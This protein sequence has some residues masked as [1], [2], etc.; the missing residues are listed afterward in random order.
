MDIGEF[1]KGLRHARQERNLYLVCRFVMVLQQR[2]ISAS[3]STVERRALNK[4]LERVRAGHQYTML[5]YGYELARWLMIT[6]YFSQRKSLKMSGKD[7]A[8]IQQTARRLCE[9]KNYEQLASLLHTCEYFGLEL[10]LPLTDA[11]RGELERA[12][13]EIV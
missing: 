2:G 8:Q 7:V 1:L 13:V 9:C 6:Y 5:P 12:A 10:I 11:E 3:L 4:A